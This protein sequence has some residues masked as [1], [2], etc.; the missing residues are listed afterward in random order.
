MV[1]PFTID[2]LAGCHK[3][4]DGVSLIFL[5]L[6]LSLLAVDNPAKALVRLEHLV[7]ETKALAEPALLALLLA[8]LAVLVGPLCVVS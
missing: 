4:P 2:R 8:S 5:S 7:A 6:S 3:T 1:V